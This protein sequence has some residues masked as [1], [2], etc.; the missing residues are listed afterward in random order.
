M[1]GRADYDYEMPAMPISDMDVEALLTRRE[2]SD[3]ELTGMSSALARIDLQRLEIGLEERVGIFS[4]RAAALARQSGTSSTQT[5]PW[6]RRIAPKLVPNALSVLM[7]I[8]L[9]GVAVA[10]DEAAPGDFLYGIDR[11]LERIGVNNGGVGERLSEASIVADEGDAVE[12]LNH[13]AEA[14]SSESPEAADA[15]LSAARTLA[16]SDGIGAR[17]EVAGMLEWMST[18]D[19]TGRAFGQGVAERARQVGG[20]DGIDPGPGLAPD[21]EEP[22][23]ADDHANAAN[24]G[25]NGK[26]NNG[27]PDPGGKGNGSPGD[28]AP[29]R[30]NR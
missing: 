5:V 11:A 2:P 24:P 28:T 8:G 20:G 14:V 4:L 19:A 7:V 21:A 23:D 15:L 13:A 18:T 1:S 3:R 30:P 16:T 17:E 9:A 27:H 25:G 22:D 6:W 26:G 10:S 12:A 29:G